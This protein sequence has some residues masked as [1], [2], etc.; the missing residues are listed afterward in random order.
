MALN[1][2]R[3]GLVANSVKRLLTFVLGL[4]TCLL[5][6]MPQATAAT[7]SVSIMNFGFNPVSPTVAQGSAVQWTQFDST[8][9]TTTSNALFWR[10]AHLSQGQTFQTT[11]WS[12]G[13]FGY[14]CELH[15]DM[16]GT[17]RVPLKASGTATAGWTIRWSSQSSTPTTR[18]FDVQIKRPGSTSFVGWRTDVTSRSAFFNPSKNGTYQFRARTRNLSNGKNSGW[19]PTKSVKIS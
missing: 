19:S 17:I 4:S 10:S 9:H 5:V 14:H 13:S 18:A 3:A 6:A 15:P 16:T 7:V 8:E 1:R 2:N 12:A 11:F